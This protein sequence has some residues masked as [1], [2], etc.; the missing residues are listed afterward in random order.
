MGLFQSTATVPEVP[1]WKSNIITDPR[2]AI[3]VSS[4]VHLQAPNRHTQ[5]SPHELSDMH[6]ADSR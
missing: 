5:L 4:T 6:G 2:T 1:S 3:Q